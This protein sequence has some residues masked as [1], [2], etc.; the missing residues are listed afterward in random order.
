MFRAYFRNSYFLICFIYLISTGRQATAKERAHGGVLKDMD[1]VIDKVKLNLG[2]KKATFM[3]Q[4]E[5]D[6]NFLAELNIMDY[7]LL[8]SIKYKEYY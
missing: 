2:V 7:S 8:V 1:L 6:A 3:V 5:K 4:V